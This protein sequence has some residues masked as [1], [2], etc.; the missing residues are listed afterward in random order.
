MDLNISVYKTNLGNILNEMKLNPET[1]NG[2]TSLEKRFLAL[3]EIGKENS[4]SQKAFNRAKKEYTLLL[5]D[6]YSVC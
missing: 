1:L 6:N 5:R 3:G 4:K 2:N